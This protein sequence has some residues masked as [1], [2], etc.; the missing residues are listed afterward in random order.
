MND[1]NCQQ[2]KTNENAEKFCPFP[3]NEKDKFFP[4]PPCK[5]LIDLLGAL[6]GL[7]ILLPFFFLIGLFIKI[8]DG[9]PVFFKQYRIGKGGAT[10]YSLEVSF[11]VGQCRELKKGFASKKR[12]KGKNFQ[13]EARSSRDSGGEIFTPNL[14]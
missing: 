9:G 10:V 5:R 3:I 4:C 2:P 1:N 7:T 12:G 14:N 13:D 8:E 6:L 11:N